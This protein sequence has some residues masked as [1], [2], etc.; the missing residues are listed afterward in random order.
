M[1][2]VPWLAQALIASDTR[3]D[4]GAAVDAVAALQPL[5]VGPEARAAVLD[6]IER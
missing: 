5:A 3:L 2:C 1:S 6:F 4:L